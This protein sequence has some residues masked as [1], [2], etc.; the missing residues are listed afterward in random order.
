MP[1]VAR[2]NQV[3]KVFS[4]HGTGYKCRAPTVQATQQG[5]SRV[6]VQGVQV[7]TLGDAMK[8][9]PASGCAPH[10]PSLSSCSSRVFAENS[11]G[12]GRIG[13]SYSGHPILS[14]SS[15]VFSS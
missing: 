2:K 12:I 5:V 7:V 13:D 3:D 9:H 4:P 14:G 11:G 10:A 15:R 8:V 6:Y 1:A